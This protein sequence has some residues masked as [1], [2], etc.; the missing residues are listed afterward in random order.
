M[1]SQARNFA[2]TSTV[3]F[4]GHPVLENTL[5]RTPF[6]ALASRIQVREKLN[7]IFE[8]Q[9]FSKLLAQAFLQ[10]GATQQLLAD[11]GIELIRMASKGKIRIASQIIQNSLRIATDKKMNHLPDEVVMESIEMMR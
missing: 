8:Q 2:S 5:N 11:S 7:P 9:R 3:W 1:Y 4:L 6:A 10:A